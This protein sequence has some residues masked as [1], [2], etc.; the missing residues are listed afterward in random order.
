VDEH[1]VI[2]VR[3]EF[4]GDARKMI[5]NGRLDATDGAE[6]QNELS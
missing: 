3:A 6:D 1:Y 4:F 2:G 5:I